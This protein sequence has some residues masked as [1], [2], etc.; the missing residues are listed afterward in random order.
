MG[1]RW[2]VDQQMG[3]TAKYLDLNCLCLLRRC[4]T[5]GHV[6]TLGPCNFELRRPWE[7]RQA[8]RLI[9]QFPRVYSTE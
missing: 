5:F 9:H 8:V 3:E 2:H 4:R 6:A 7:A 1:R